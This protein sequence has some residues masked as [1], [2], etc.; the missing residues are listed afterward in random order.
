M[1]KVL[2]ICLILTMV[3]GCLAGC[4]D[5]SG[6]GTQKTTQ[7]GD[8]KTGGEDKSTA[9]N[10]ASAGTEDGNKDEAGSE[11]PAGSEAPTGETQAPAA[12]GEGFKVGINYF[13][14]ASYALLLLKK[15]SEVVVEAFGGTPMSI[16]D[17]FNVEK[18]ITDVENMIQSG[19]DGIVFWGPVETLYPTVSQMCLDAEV[20][21]VLCDKAPTNQDV[22]D[23]LLENP[24]FAGAITPDNRS[25]GVGMAEY[26]L[27]QGWKT[28]IISAPGIG[29]ASG[30]PRMEGFKEVFEAGG[31]EILDELHSDDT[32][33]AQTKTEDSLVA[34]PNPDFIYCTGS[35]FGIAA[36]GALE[37]FD[38]D[39]TV[40]TSDFDET[41]LNALGD[42]KLP[43]LNGDSLICG[44]YSAIML[45]NFLDGTPLKD[46]SGK[47]P[48]ITD[49]KFFFIQPNQLELYNKFWIQEHCYSDEEMR[50]MSGK[51]NP[52]FDYNAFLDIVHNYSFAERLQ[53]K[54]SEGKITEDELKAAGVLE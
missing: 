16:D 9:G 35:D 26:A 3:I 30:T 23:E 39:T 28:C 52:D 43:I 51:N 6:G 42:G 49:V 15:N 29:D 38:Y 47:A 2:S 19:C 45:Q 21:F 22:I 46:D 18:I 20:P 24:Y 4:S 34:N 8:N 1:K 33:S 7:A 50:Q 36:L 32:A 31:G 12:S 41:V 17:E 37:K 44:T 25:Y 48:W 27:E 40:L 10:D 14:S 5:N 53:A 11:S 54:M 13:G